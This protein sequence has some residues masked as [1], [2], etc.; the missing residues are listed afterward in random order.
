VPDI[1]LGWSK[2]WIG[3]TTLA[4][5]AS[6]V[7]WQSFGFDLDGTCTNSSTC[8]G[9]SDQQSCRAST[10]QIAFDGA[11]C[12]D[13]TF[14][15]LQPVA[16]AVPEVGRRFGIG[17][18]VFNCNIWRGSYNM[19]W[20]LSNYNGNSDDS[21]VRVDFYV[22]PGLSRLPGWECPVDG[23]ESKYPLW[24][25]ATPWLIDPATLTG[26]ISTAS[27]LPASTVADPHA[28]VRGGYLVASFPDGASVRLAGDGTK[29]RGFAMRVH[30]AVWTGQLYKGQDDI[31]RMRDGL[32]A[33]RIR[34]ADL[35]QSFR[36]IGLCKGIGLDSF[37]Q[38]VTDYVDQ[39]ADLLSDGAVDR[40]RD[41]DAMSFGVAFEASQVTPGMSSDAVPLVE[42]CAPG[43]AIEDC[44]ASCGDG[45]VN[46]AEKCDVAIAAGKAGA[47]PS[48]C[49]APD[50][51][52]TSELRGSGCAAECVT[53]PVTAVGAADGCCPPNANQTTDRDCRPKCG[54][55]V[56]EADE[57]CDPMSSCPACRTN[58]KCLNVVSRGSAATCDL[59]CNYNPIKNC[60]SGDGCCPDGCN[61]SNDNDCSGSCGDGHIDANETCESSGAMACPTSCDDGDSCT[62]D[63]ATG[64]R[65]SCNIR[66][67]HVAITQA[68]SGDGCCPA[69]AN[70]N[71][72]TD[73]GATCGNQMTEAGEECDDG[74]DTAGDGCTPD[75]KIESAV[76][77]CLA[78]I[79]TNDR[80][81]CA[82]CNCEK[83][84][85]QA[86]ACYG[87]NADDAA[88]CGDLVE[89]GLD[90]GCTSDD[91]YC[92]DQPVTLCALGGGNGPCRAEVEAATGST[93]SGEIIAHA[94]DP[95]YPVGRANLL[96]ACAQ[97]NCADVC[98]LMK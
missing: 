93:K 34:S 43:T 51:C 27:K 28:Y 66:C 4:G 21:D 17:E 89:C 81:D 10:M 70:A 68:M 82:R 31:W 24:R 42:C 9:P 13:N 54:N 92:G 39:N 30:Q 5:E 7:A 83:C 33:G 46:G 97:S 96:S 90:H 44:N 47:C 94:D 14:A 80:P 49:N 15:S 1:Y 98:G 85:M 2:L 20:K 62:T 56:I 40:T 78:K 88:R 52:T 74:N 6:D 67:T 63:V 87:G 73:C 58:N 86:L 23:F 53:S 35:I 55:G 8:D 29:F 84:Q 25:P 95:D 11:L 61:T 41:C 79:G 45:R 57:T 16:A 77:Q 59:K 12:R 69:G 71:T 22:S 18:S 60:R 3:E 32:F 26:S 19:L 38:D 48:S 50:A 72:D 91:C 65:S 64:S 76:T 36:Q 37:Y 75:C